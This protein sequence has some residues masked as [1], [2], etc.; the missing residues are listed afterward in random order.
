MAV[1]SALRW[2][3]VLM[4]RVPDRLSHAV[5]RRTA[6]ERLRSSEVPGV[7]LVV[8]HGNVCRSPY[9]EAA[10][11]RR[12]EA[13]GLEIQVESAGFLGPS[14]PAPRDA[15]DAAARRGTD[16]RAHRSRVVDKALLDFADLIVT[17]EPGQA[18]AVT[19][20]PSRTARNV[21]VLG[22]LDPRP[23]T[24]RSIVDPYGRPPETYTEC[25]DRIDR[26]LDQLVRA[27]ARDEPVPRAV[28]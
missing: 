6:I 13:A 27:L 10:L 18:R 22:D 3:L 28:Y 2:L 19:A 26:C 25:Y 21:L 24:G 8:C 17:M 20:R 9:A 12:F 14:R 15:L 7:I 11:R 4:K 23:G 5:R 16:M 1:T